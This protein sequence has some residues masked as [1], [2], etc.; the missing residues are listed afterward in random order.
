MS[1]PADPAGTP[2][3]IVLDF[4]FT[5]ESQARWFDPTE[6]FDRAV[7]DLLLPLW[8]PACAGAFDRWADTPDGAVALLVLLDQVPRNCFRGDC[9]AFESDV[10]ARAVARRAVDRGFDLALPVER[11]LFIYM[12]FEHSEDLGTQVLS[13]ALFT[14]LHA[15]DAEKMK[16][17]A[18]HEEIIRRFGRF[19]HRNA[20]LGR[21]STAEELAFLQE[22]MSSF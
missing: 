9:R 18:R 21:V 14:N 5:P 7:T 19:P 3:S 8:P 1:A 11:R 20:C 12:P 4:W 15:G 16:W 13:M 2:P 17:A 6:A 22:P 10:Q